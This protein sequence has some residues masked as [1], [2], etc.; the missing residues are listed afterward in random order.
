MAE[1]FDVLIVGSGQN[2]L[3]LGNYLARAGLKVAV[4]ERRLEAGGGVST[5]EL[6]VNGFWHNTGSAIIDGQDLVPLY[7]DLKLDR[8]YADYVVPPV[9]S[10]LLTPTNKAVTVHADGTLEG[11]SPADERAWRQV[12]SAAGD[13]YAGLLKP[14]SG[15]GADWP[16]SSDSRLAEFAKLTPRQVVQN[17]FEMP[18]VQALALWHVLIP[19]MVPPDYEGMGWVVP[20]ALAE[21]S[22]ARLFL[23]GQHELIQALW[24]ALIRA[25]GDVRDWHEVQRIRV[26]DGK[27]VG[28]E[29]AGGETLGARCIVSNAGLQPTFT[30]LL[31]REA[32]PGALGS[33]VGQFKVDEFSVFALHLALREPPRYRGGGSADRAYRVNLGLDSPADFDTLFAEIRAGKLPSQ[34]ALMVNVSTSL[35]TVQAHPNKHVAVAWQIVP[36]G[37][38]DDPRYAQELLRRWREYAPNLTDENIIMKRAIS[39]AEFAGKWVNM[40]DGALSG[41]RM[42]ADQMGSRRPLPELAGFRTPIENLY[43]C[44]GCMSPGLGL[45]GAQGYVAA[46][47]IARDLGANVW[48]E[49]N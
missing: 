8:H 22:R 4:L 15:D 37:T 35:D 7:R 23:G 48:W 42:S 46:G 27:A 26:E 16:A 5:E 20:L 12:I 10:T 39:P 28:V 38:S 1:E 21:A 44:G 14:P 49:T 43:L 41:G 2:S 19:R 31:D 33:T 47:V 13:A 9:Q 45:F 30:R 6:D 32:V 29:F 17:L 36:P 34:L 11:F 18:E 3:V 25:G 24:N 40:A